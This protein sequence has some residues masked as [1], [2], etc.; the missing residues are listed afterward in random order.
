[1]AGLVYARDEAL[2]LSG[3][4]PLERVRPGRP[5]RAVTVEAR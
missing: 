4:Q 3:E 2:V 5:H 1:M